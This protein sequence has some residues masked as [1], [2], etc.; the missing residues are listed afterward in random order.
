MGVQMVQW[1]HSSAESSA[2]PFPTSLATHWCQTEAEAAALLQ[3]P[4]LLPLR[5]SRPLASQQPLEGGGGH[6]VCII[7]TTELNVLYQLWKENEHTSYKRT[8]SRK[9]FQHKKGRKEEGGEAASAASAAAS[10]HLKNGG[11]QH[12]STAVLDLWL[13]RRPRASASNVASPAS[14]PFLKRRLWK[15]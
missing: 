1:D 5:C 12:C 4:M 14:F 11:S 7:P 13:T 10:W 8:E 15:K 3:L 2:T 9:L 6:C